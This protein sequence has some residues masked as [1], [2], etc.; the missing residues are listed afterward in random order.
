MIR[1]LSN[2]VVRAQTIGNF[3]RRQLCGGEVDV[4]NKGV[5]K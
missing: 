4:G 5:L 2:E 3:K 1:T